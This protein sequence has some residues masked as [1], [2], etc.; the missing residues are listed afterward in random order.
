[1]TSDMISGSEA[2][3]RRTLFQ[4]RRRRGS[5][6]HKATWLTEIARLK[7]LL[8]PGS[9]EIAAFEAVEVQGLTFKAAAAKLGFS[10]RQLYRVRR[11]MIDHLLTAPPQHVAVEPLQP[12]ERYLELGD[13]LFTRG[14]SAQVLPLVQRSLDRPS[15]TGNVVEALVLRAKSLCD[16]EDFEAARTALSEARTFVHNHR[17]E[18]SN[19]HVR[20]IV[21]AHCY[22]LYRRGLYDKA[23]EAAQR[24]LAGAVPRPG[25]GPY[26]IRAL[27]RAFIFLGVMHQEGG[28]PQASIVCFDTAHDILCA[29]PVPPAAELV[30]VLMQS[31]FSRA[32]IPGEIHRAR[33]EAH[34]SLHD[35]Q[36]HGLTFETIWANLG[37][38]MIEEVAG[39]PQ[40]GLAHA[41]AALSLARA[42]FSGDPLARTLFLTSRVESALDLHGEALAHVREADPHVG[43]TGLMRAILYVAQARVHRAAKSIKE[44]IESA[45]RAIEELESKSHTH[46]IGMPYLARATAR[47]A[48]G[49]TRVHDDVEAAVFYLERGGSVKDLALSLELSAQVCGKRRDMERARELRAAL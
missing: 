20:E 24:A 3:L 45:T 32:A 1:M 46:Y 14:H 12:R 43:K 44:T 18:R 28:S 22:E 36:W 31:A 47:R 37:I 19:H 39:R 16:I 38:A 27:A 34:Q 9:P 2:A 40:D 42:S 4:L 15:G 49:D 13:T 8:R 10:E 23:I 11:S 5:Y 17:D 29:L 30:Q 33:L 35:A 6:A 26:E 48:S 21:I 25:A 7:G 41:H